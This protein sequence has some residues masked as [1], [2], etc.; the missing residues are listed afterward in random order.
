MQFSNRAAWA[1]HEFT[2]HRVNRFWTCPECPEKSSTAVGWATHLVTVHQRAFS[3]PNV[4]VARDMAYNTELRPVENEECPFCRVILKRPRRAFIKHVGSHM[5]EIALMALPRDCL[6]DLEDESVISREG[7]MGT[8]RLPASNGVTQNNSLPGLSGV[9]SSPNSVSDGIGE[10]QM[11]R[12]LRTMV[13]DSGGA[14]EPT[15][16]PLFSR[17]DQDP[18]LECPFTFLKCFRQ[19]PPSNEH[20]WIQHSLEHFRVNRRRPRM[21]DPPKT[22]SCC[23]CSQTFQASSGAISWRKRMDHVKLHHTFGHRLAAARH[24]FALVEYLWQNGL[25]SPADYHDL[26]APV[27]SRNIRPPSMETSRLPAGNDF[28]QNNS[29]PDASSAGSPK[30]P[31]PSSEGMGET[32]M[33]RALGNMV[34]DPRSDSAFRD[35]DVEPQ[36]PGQL[37]YAPAHTNLVVETPSSGPA[38]PRTDPSKKCTCIVC[39]GIECPKEAKLHHCLVENCHFGSKRWGDLLRHTTFSHCKVPCRF[40][41]PVVG[42]KRSIIGF[43]EKHNFE[44]HFKRVHGVIAASAGEAS[45]FSDNTVHLMQFQ[46]ASDEPSTKISPLSEAK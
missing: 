37:Q 21:V 28:T 30:A 35:S 44:D 23:F 33:N 45:S 15:S 12:S 13:P 16:L 43:N 40:I 7:S 1:D 14:L 11:N 31:D 4:E 46:K 9:G 2:K 22:N 18:V 17:S 19:F 3:G 24:D 20:E 25:L 29:R 32:Q 5:E 26:T 10:R 41:C 39:L 42:C 38:L 36:I 8:S 6:S 27:E 34:P